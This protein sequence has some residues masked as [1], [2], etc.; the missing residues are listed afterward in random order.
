MNNIDT[1]TRK[2]RK[3]KPIIKQE[4]NKVKRGYGNKP[5]GHSLHLTMEDRNKYVE[6]Y[7]RNMPDEVP[8]EHSRPYNHPVIF[9]VDDEMYE[10]IKS[11]ENGIRVY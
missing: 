11:S 6:E 1:F 4:W 3:M 7:W 2:K 8:D 9:D 10:K 5:D